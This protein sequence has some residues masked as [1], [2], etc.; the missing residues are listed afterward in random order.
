[1]QKYSFSQVA[2]ATFQIINQDYYNNS[3]KSVRVITQLCN[4]YSLSTAS[5]NNV[6]VKSVEVST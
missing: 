4:A 2:A 6:I 5:D 3:I 1:M